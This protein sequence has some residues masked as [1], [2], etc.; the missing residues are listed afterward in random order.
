M[1]DRRRFKRLWHSQFVVENPKQRRF[2]CTLQDSLPLIQ[3]KRSRGS[4]NAEP[5]EIFFER[6]T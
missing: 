3:K 6:G 2:T 4:I 1:D 5:I